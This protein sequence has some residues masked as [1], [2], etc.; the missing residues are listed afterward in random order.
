MHTE[1]VLLQLTDIH[2]AY[3]PGKPVLQDFSLTVQPGQVNGVLGPNGAGKSTLLRIMAGL[4][5]PQS[6]QVQFDTQ[7]VQ[8]LSTRKRAQH[9]AYLP[10]AINPAFALTAFEAVCLGRYPHTGILGAL[11]AQDLDISRKAMERTGTAEFAD[12]PFQELSGGERQRVL[13]A[14]ILA[15]E[16]KVMLLDEPIAALD[17]PHQAECLHLLQ[18]LAREGY[19]VV[20]VLHDINLAA[21]YCDHLALLNQAHGLQTTGTPTEVLTASHLEAAYGTPFDVSTHPKDG[22]LLIQPLLQEAAHE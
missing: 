17:M 9:L 19:T 15:Q 11:S 21:R 10:Q 22:A 13:L 3:T 4:E 14:S 1:N 7:A 20:I 16:P 5:T 8:A 12:R 6:G 2:F 18:G